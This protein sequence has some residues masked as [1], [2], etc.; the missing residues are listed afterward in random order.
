MRT[1]DS[2]SLPGLLR[3]RQAA[4]G[5]TTTT[6]TTTTTPP[7]TDLIHSCI[8]PNRTIY[9]VETPD[10]HF[11]RFTPDGKYLIGFNRT[12][13]GLQIFRVLNAS[14]S[15]A[16]LVEAGCVPQKSEFW[17]FF[18]LAWSQ[19][20]TNF[21][22]SLHRDLCLVTSNMRHIIAVKLRRSDPNANANVNMDIPTSS[23]T[24]GLSGLQRQQL[25]RP[26]VLGCI[27]AMED[28]TIMIIDIR[29]G[30]LVDTREYPGDIIYLSGHNGISIYEDRLCFLSLKHQ[31]LRILRVKPDGH[32]VDLQEI[33]WYTR[34][35]DS[36]C[37]DTLRI[38]EERVLADRALAIKR[39]SECMALETFGGCI[40]DTDLPIS[41]KRRK[42]ISAQNARA[43]MEQ[44]S[45]L[46]RSN[47]DNISF[48]GMLPSQ[49]PLPPPLLLSE[50]VNSQ[51]TDTMYPNVPSS[52]TMH[53]PRTSNIQLTTSTG[54][55]LPFIFP[56]SAQAQM[57]QTRE[58]EPE[59]R[60]AN[61]AANVSFAEASFI[62]A[63]RLTGLIGPD[64][65]I[66]PLVEAMN[67]NLPANADR[68][69]LMPMQAIQH[70]APH[71]RML[72]SR[73]MQHP[74]ARLDN[75]ADSD[76]PIIE[77]S[78]TSAP[79][80]GLKQRLLGALFMQAKR[81]NDSGLALQYFY[82]TYRQYEGLVLWRAQFVSCSRLLLRFV[83][84]QV[85]TSRSHAPRSSAVSSSTMANSFSLL[86]EY[87]MIEARFLRIWDTSD[88]E[89]YEE[90]EKRLDIYRAPMSASRGLGGSSSGQAPSIS[91]DL[92]LR[93]AFETSQAAIRTARA[94]GPVQ[95][96]RKASMLL[97][98]APQ[99]MQESPL[100]D[101]SRFKCNLRVRQTL[102]KLRPAS[103]SP[104]R[105]YDRVTGALKFVLSPTPYIYTLPSSTMTP[106]AVA[107]GPDD[108]A[109]LRPLQYSVADGMDVMVETLSPPPPPPP[110]PPSGV[111]RSGAILL[112]TGGSGDPRFVLDS[113]AAGAGTAA[114]AMS[115]P[116]S[117][118]VSASGHKAGVVYLFHPALPLVLSTRN[119]TGATAYP[120][121][122]IHFWQGD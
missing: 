35:D 86:G 106:A 22:E 82:R 120:M 16:Q 14:A 113:A 85:A 93:D 70:L 26:N 119:D 83:P 89:L 48:F 87:D 56:F 47:S 7:H 51:N 118:N 99:C 13:S 71:Y 115:P 72:F 37:E 21:G 8:Y 40:D 79:H 112:P 90:I 105:F 2:T 38:R 67:P 80:S 78:L 44:A 25:Q 57:L 88:N 97:P 111:M 17:H 43:A 32:L 5:P 4:S 104:I 121:S 109:A 34:E 100:L 39:K 65:A 63:A 20:Y 24:A 84:L 73:A 36:I 41:V 98:F 101:P 59:I 42:V 96:S 19:S 52:S 114:P 15:T 9:N 74:A 64:V 53:R 12:L 54:E 30:Q 103:L 117:Q 46:V 62:T 3:R 29:T 27:K 23:A 107:Q 69:A 110:P 11:K 92:Y 1:A 81:A 58:R 55:P 102:E 49:P 116:P 108:P 45:R 95:A 76:I 10:C 6:A 31:C 75:L 60:R 66:G 33:G 77:P 50:S 61:M 122:N 18:K 94:G 68:S 91:N 28:I